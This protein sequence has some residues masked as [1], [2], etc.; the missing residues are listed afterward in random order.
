MLVSVPV[1]VDMAV[2]VVSVVSW[3]ESLQAR[4][5]FAMFNRVFEAPA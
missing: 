4:A 2:W 3:A 1:T 5:T